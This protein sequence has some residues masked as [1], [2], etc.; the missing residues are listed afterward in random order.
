VKVGQALTEEGIDMDLH[1]FSNVWRE[2]TNMLL[3]QKVGM[4]S[5]LRG[6]ANIINQ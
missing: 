6:G 1:Q 3:A 4:E 5:G 2:R